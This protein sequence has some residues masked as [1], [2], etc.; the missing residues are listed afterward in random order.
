M[1]IDLTGFVHVQVDSNDVGKTFCN[2]TA[3]DSKAILV[4]DYDI[5]FFNFIG[6]LRMHK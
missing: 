1:R 3:S 5:V 6:D 2:S 4:C